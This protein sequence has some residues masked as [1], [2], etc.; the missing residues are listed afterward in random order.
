M[1][2]VGSPRCQAEEI[3]DAR[4]VVAVYI[5]N[6]RL[7]ADVQGPVAVHSPENSVH[8]FAQIEPIAPIS[9][10]DAVEGGDAVRSR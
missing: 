2:G 10:A 5:A 4:V 1:P 3:V 8:F 6:A 9:M 7:L